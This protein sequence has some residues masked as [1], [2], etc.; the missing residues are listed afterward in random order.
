MKGNISGTGKATHNS[1][2]GEDKQ[3]DN[4]KREITSETSFE[5]GSYRHLC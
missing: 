1:D 2:E 5:Q 4:V 3:F